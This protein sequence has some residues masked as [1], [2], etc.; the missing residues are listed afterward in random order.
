MGG[1]R[2]EHLAR[3]RVIEL[4]VEQGDAV[5]QAEA[6]VVDRVKVELCA[7]Q[8]RRSEGDQRCIR[9][10]GAA[11][12]PGAVRS[13]STM[14]SAPGAGASSDLKSLGNAELWDQARTRR[15][16]PTRGVSRAAEARRIRGR[17]VWAYLMVTPSYVIHRLFQLSRPH[18]FTGVERGNSAILVDAEDTQRHLPP[19]C[20]SA[21]THQNFLAFDSAI[22]A[23]C[24]RS[25]E[26]GKE[27]LGGGW[28]GFAEEAAAGRGHVAPEYMLQAL[29][30]FTNSTGCHSTAI[31]RSGIAQLKHESRANVLCF[32]SIGAALRRCCWRHPT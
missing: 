26:G 29:F 27:A 2:E 25:D 32:G 7:R 24:G 21:T 4:Y 31:N 8:A 28:C 11:L 22:E 14:G 30:S 5:V 20:T 17:R 23:C 3:L 19:C 18:C 13:N 9:G 16:D 12:H 15:K 10:A 1:E 6:A